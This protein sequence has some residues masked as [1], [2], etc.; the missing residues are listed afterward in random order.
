MWRKRYSEEGLWLFDRASGQNVLL[1]EFV[2]HQYSETPAQVSIALTN[3]C[4]WKCAHCFVEKGANRIDKK[5]LMRWL[6]ELDGNGTLGVGFGGGEPLLYDGFVDVCRYVHEETGMACTFTTNGSLLTE[7]MLESLSPYV[8]FVRL[9]TNGHFLDFEKCRAIAARIKLG[10]NY[11]LTDET[12]C[13]FSSELNR[14]EKAGV[15]EVLVLPCVGKA[16]EIT[17]LTDPRRSLESVLNYKTGSIRIVA[18]AIAGRLISDSVDIPGD[19]GLRAY[20]HITAAGVIKRD[21]FSAKGVYIGNRSIVAAI[22][23]LEE[24]K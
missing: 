17:G 6:R 3:S 8:D 24:N 7:S 15:K 4:N 9:S 14:A 5:D 10:I 1:D 18:S 11:L 16:G 2:C 22:K 21:S 12:E 19:K 20:A 23:E 13:R